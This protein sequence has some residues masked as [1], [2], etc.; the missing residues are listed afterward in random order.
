MLKFLRDEDIFLCV[1]LDG[2]EEEHDR[3]RVFED[4]SKTAEI[5]F[6]DKLHMIREFD[7]EY[8]NTNVRFQPTINGNS[9]IKKV[10]D[11]F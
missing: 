5:V 1:S 3:Y 11:F 2:P 4:G 9:D 6:F 8:Y 7:K 10:Y